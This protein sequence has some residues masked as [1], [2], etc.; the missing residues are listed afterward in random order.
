VGRGVRPDIVEAIGLALDFVDAALNAFR[1]R[2]RTLRLHFRWEKES[3]MLMDLYASLSARGATAG[4]E[5]STG[6]RG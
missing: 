5:A 6:E 4:T 3:Q 2:A 1:E